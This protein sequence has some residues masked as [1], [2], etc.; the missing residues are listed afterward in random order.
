MSECPPF[1]RLSNIPLSMYSTR[2][3][4]AAD[5]HLGRVHFLAVVNDAAMDMGVQGSV[6]VPAFVSF[7]YRP[8]SGIAGSY[9][10]PVFNLLR[11][12]V[13]KKI[14]FVLCLFYH[15]KKAKAGTINFSW[16]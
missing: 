3:H 8:S 11:N 13:F 10:H 5:G 9:D 7:G 4:S 15:N 14:H 1:L 16:I 6:R 12:V 2:V